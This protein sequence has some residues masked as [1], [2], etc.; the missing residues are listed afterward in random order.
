MSVMTPHLCYCLFALLFFFSFSIVVKGYQHY[1]CFWRT[2]V[3]K[4]IILF[5]KIYFFELGVVAHACNSSYSGGG[6]CEDN[7]LRP[8]WARI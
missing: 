5:I 2:R 6:D 4:I 8:A 3:L 1:Y 7:S